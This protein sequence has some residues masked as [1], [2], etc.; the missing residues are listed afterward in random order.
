MTL[1]KK[2]KSGSW[3]IMAAGSLLMASPACAKNCTLSF[4]ATPAAQTLQLTLATLQHV[5]IGT[6]KQN[7]NAA[8]SYNLVV[9]SA[10]CPISPA[11]AKLMN[12]LSGEFV[13]YS[14]EFDNK[15]TKGGIDVVPQLLAQS[16]AAQV[17]RYEGS[18]FGLRT[19]D[20]FVDFTGAVMLAEG[21]Y[22]D[23]LSVTININ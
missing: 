3:G 16:C 2:I 17:A 15:T 19:S 21:T 8:S 9:E 14:V 6:L 23:T 1:F 18:A 4:A 7:C 12:Q 20:I 13:S 22:S 10:N 5:Q 11:G